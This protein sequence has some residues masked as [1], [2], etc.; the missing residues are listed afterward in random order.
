MIVGIYVVMDTQAKVTMKPIFYEAEEV[1]I[2]DFSMALTD[3]KNTMS[4]NPDDYVLYH[5][6]SYCDESMQIDQYDPRRV[7]YGLDAVKMRVEKMARLKALQD[8]IEKI[9]GE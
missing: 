9:E 6:G 7:I 5:I 3:P 8:Q 2:R 4:Q 1:A